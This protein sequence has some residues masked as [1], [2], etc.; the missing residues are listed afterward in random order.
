MPKRLSTHK[1]DVIAGLIAARQ[2]ILDLALKTPPRRVEQV[3]LGEW[4]L[5]DLLAHLAGWDQT[6]EGAARALLNG[7][8]PA[9]LDRHDED[10]CSYNADLVARFGQ[11]TFEE[12]LDRMRAAHKSLIGFLGTIEQ[13]D[14]KRITPTGKTRPSLSALLNNE[15]RD[16]WT[17]AGQIR[18]FL[19]SLDSTGHSTG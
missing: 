13:D 17:H 6:N 2:R 1:N 14:F 9:V 11:G 16:E 19:N 5:K 10:W 15:I 12:V 18:E 3:F 4:S 8:R 7:E